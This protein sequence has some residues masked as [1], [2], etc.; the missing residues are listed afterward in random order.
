[1]RQACLIPLLIG[2]FFGCFGG[3][4]IWGGRSAGEAAARAEQ[5]SPVSATILEDSPIDREV[6]VEGRI[7]ER[8]QQRFG[9][10]VA[11]IREEYRGSDDEG[12]PEWDED[13]HMTPPLLLDLADGRVQVENDT[14]R[15]ENPPVEWQEDGALRW[16][17]STQEGTKR[18][19]GFTAHNRVMAIGV[20]VE[21]QEGRAL[22]AEVLFGGTRAEY[23]EQNQRAA[24]VLPSI[25]GVFLAICVV[26]LVVALWIFVR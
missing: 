21:G 24:S 19:Q 1:M 6:L 11:Y 20:I 7:S 13:E 17:S 26:L 22:A 3:L 15:I 9:E 10:F 2:L 5:L 18:Y 23:I 4:F 16:N 8:N 14:Y 25:G 12:D